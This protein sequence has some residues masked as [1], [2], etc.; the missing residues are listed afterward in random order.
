M[1]IRFSEKI[2]DGRLYTP[3][4]AERE[5][6]IPRTSIYAY[7]KNYLGRVGKKRLVTVS[8]NST[9]FYGQR[10]RECLEERPLPG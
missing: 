7:I 9:Q 5:I 8:R 1:R 3:T 6:N 10:L 2:V 4:M